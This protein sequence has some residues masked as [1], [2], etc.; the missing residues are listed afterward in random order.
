M[1]QEPSTFRRYGL[2]ADVSGTDPLHAFELCQPFP[3]DNQFYLHSN[4][5]SCLYNNRT[6]VTIVEVKDLR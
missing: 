5:T 2:G 1:T 6:Q 3:G 4:I